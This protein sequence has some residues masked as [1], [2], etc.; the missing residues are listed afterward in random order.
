METS[1]E[2]FKKA[3]SKRRAKEFDLLNTLPEEY[4]IIQKRFEDHAQI[5]VSFN[6]DLLKPLIFEKFPKHLQ[7]LITIDPSYPITPPKVHALT[8]VSDSF[9]L[10][11]IKVLSKIVR[12]SDAVR[13]T[14]SHI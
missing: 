2:N 4:K 14:R 1:E 10:Y 5:Q 13:S 6:N 12:L 7:F 3:L 11:L 9:S 8:H